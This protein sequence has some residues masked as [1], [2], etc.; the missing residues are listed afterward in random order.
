MTQS[1]VSQHM[2]DLEISLG[3]ELFTRGP[4]GVKLTSA[5]KTLYSYTM[6]IFQLL[7][8]AESAVSTVANLASREI[9]IGATPGISI[10]LLPEWIPAFRTKHANLNVTI[11]TGIC[12]EIIDLLQSKEIDVGIIEGELPPKPPQWLGI[13]LLDEVEQKIVVG[14]KHPWWER[15][16]IA[17]HELKDESMIMRQPGSQTRIWLDQ[18]LS[19]HEVKPVIHAAFDNVESIKRAVVRGQG[20]AILPPYSVQEEVQVGQVRTL[21]VSDYPLQRIIK[22]IWNRGRPPTPSVR[23]FLCYLEAYL[24]GIGEEA[25][26]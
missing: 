20:V 10:Y 2:R 3:T 24:P 15:E 14:V 26:D 21:C 4:R 1:A 7:G 23:T 12:T 9:M 5:G 22:L 18:T 8:E 16:S 11:Q 6:Q 17:L 19:A 13:R 25:K